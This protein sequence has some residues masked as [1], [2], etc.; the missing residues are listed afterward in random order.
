MNVYR[1]KRSS[2]TSLKQRGLA[3]ITASQRSYNYYI[4]VY[5]IQGYNQK[6]FTKPDQKKRLKIMREVLISIVDIIL[7]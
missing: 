7:S 6:R 4:D 2:R 3:K 1:N 5:K